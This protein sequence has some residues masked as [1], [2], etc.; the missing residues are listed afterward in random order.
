MFVCS[1]R[2]GGVIYRDMMISLFVWQWWNHVVLF[3][4]R[5]FIDDCFTR[6]CSIPCLL[7]IY[8]MFSVYLDKTEYKKV[9]YKDIENKESESYSR[10]SHFNVN[11]WQYYYHDDKRNTILRYRTVNNYACTEW[12][13]R[14]VV[15]NL[16]KWWRVRNIIDDITWC[17]ICSGFFLIEQT[18]MKRLSEI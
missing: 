8:C 10:V 12:I 4:V 9:R 11:E 18:N 14:C 1:P 3:R 7:I 5:P 17:N 13:N 15:D 6:L 2:H 16:N